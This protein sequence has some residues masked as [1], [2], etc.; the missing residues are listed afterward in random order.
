[1]SLNLKLCNA[2][3]REVFYRLELLRN[4]VI[5]KYGISDPEP[6]EDNGTSWVQR[7]RGL[8]FDLAVTVDEGEYSV[9]L[10]IN[11]SERQE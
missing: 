8:E 9:A 5:K 11:S 4:E 1:M 10:M 7:W 3:L 6:W 2:N